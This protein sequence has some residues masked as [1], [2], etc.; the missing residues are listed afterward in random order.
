MKQLTVGRYEIENARVGDQI[1]VETYVP[2]KVGSGMDRDV[3][4][5]G[6]L[7]KVVQPTVRMPG[8]GFVWSIIELEET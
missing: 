7:K 5:T 3:R 6:T 8:C 4:K 2:A 1:S